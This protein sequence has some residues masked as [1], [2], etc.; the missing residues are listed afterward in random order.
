[1][2]RPFQRGGSGCQPK[3]MHRRRGQDGSDSINRDLQLRPNITLPEEN[4]DTLT[5]A[6]KTLQFMR[7]NGL[8]VTEF[9]EKVKSLFVIYFLNLTVLIF[10]DK[11]VLIYFNYIS[12]INLLGHIRKT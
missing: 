5:I 10:R 12:F 7:T 9:S 1:M 4:I 2:S 8:T 6:R 3:G 11:I